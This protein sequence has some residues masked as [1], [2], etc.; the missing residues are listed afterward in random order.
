MDFHNLPVE[1]N[2]MI[3]NYLD[4]KDG[5]G[6]RLVCKGLKEVAARRVFRRVCFDLDPGGCAALQNISGHDSLRDEVREVSLRRRSFLPTFHSFGAFACA[7]ANEDRAR[8][9]KLAESGQR[10]LFANYRLHASQLDRSTARLAATVWRRALTSFSEEPS[11]DFECTLNKF[12]KTFALCPNLRILSH[13][14][15]FDSHFHRWVWQGWSFGSPA[16]LKRWSDADAEALQVLAVLHALPRRNRDRYQIFVMP[17]G[18]AFWGE[19]SI[20]QL[21]TQSVYK[22]AT[23][24]ADGEL[25]RVIHSGSPTDIS[26]N[27]RIEARKALKT[28]ATDILYSSDLRLDVRHT[29]LFRQSSPSL[30]AIFSLLHQG[31]QPQKLQ[32]RIGRGLVAEEHVHFEL[33]ASSLS[34]SMITLPAEWLLNVFQKAVHLNHLDIQNTSLTQGTWKALLSYIQCKLRLRSIKLYNLGYTPEDPSKGRLFVPAQSIQGPHLCASYLLNL[35][36]Q[37][38]DSNFG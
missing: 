29:D 15:S 37:E 11:T 5:K 2:M 8:W 19:Y 16:R 4:L 9:E 6:M 28:L 12:T 22:G 7:I 3:L 34:T 36:T 21:L 35:V 38:S 26:E 33:K 1:L 10:A 18:P 30:P 17:D 23:R 31:P 25:Y 27:R 20:S 32:L 14:P 24:P 13:R